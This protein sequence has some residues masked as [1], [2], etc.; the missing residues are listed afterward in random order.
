MKFL[1]FT[2][3]YVLEIWGQEWLGE[4]EIDQN[5]FGTFYVFQVVGAEE[6]II[7]FDVAVN[8]ATFVKTLQFIDKLKAD[9]D[10]GFQSEATEFRE[11]EHSTE[12][13][14]VPL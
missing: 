14:T 6:D 3:L 5:Y 7:W 1:V 8:V 9:L 10:C 4:S 13:W 2:Q 11:I 12:T